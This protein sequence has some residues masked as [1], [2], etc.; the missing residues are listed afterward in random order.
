VQSTC[1]LIV[2]AFCRA[3][4]PCLLSFY[5]LHCKGPLGLNLDRSNIFNALDPSLL[6]QQVVVFQGGKVLSTSTIPKAAQCLPR[7]TPF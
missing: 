6:F 7:L 2:Q 1:L 5:I 4:A 3:W